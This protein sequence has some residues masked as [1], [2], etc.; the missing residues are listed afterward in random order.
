[1]MKLRFFIWLLFLCAFCV[2]AEQT[3]LPDI[4]WRLIGPFRGGRALAVAGVPGNPNQFYFGSVN[5]GVWKTND[6]GRTWEPIFD[7][8]S[9]ASIG[10]IAVAPSKPEVIYVGSGEAD[11]RS[12]IG[13]GNGMY[14]SIDG[15]KSWTHIGLTDS[16]QIGR[17]LINPQNPDEVFVAALGHAYGPNTERG[18]FH[19]TD[20]GKTWQKSLYRDA[21]TGVIDVAFGAN[22][23]MFAAMWQTRRT[24]WNV[25]PPYSGPGSGLYKSIDHGNTWKQISGHGFP[26]Q[27]VGRIGIGVSMSNPKIIFAVVDAKAG[28]LY[29]SDDDGENWTLV[30]SDQRIWQRGW[31]FGGVTV[32]PSTPDTVYVCNTTMYKSTDGGKNFV[33]FRGAP[34][35]DDYHELRIDPEDPGRMIVAADQGTVITL[36]GGKTWSSWYNQPTGQF[37]HGI[38]DDRFPYWVFGAQQDSGAAG[39]PSRTTNVDGIN[40]MQFHEVTAGGEN[41]YIAPDPLDPE[42]IY[43][44]TVEKL[45]TRTGQTLDVDPTFAYPDIYRRV[46]TLPLTFSPRDPHVLYFA[47]Q[48]LF[49]TNDGGKH[50][51]LI[52]PDMTRTEWPVPGNLNAEIAKNAS[53]LEP[54][55]GVIYSIA[56]S[57][58]VDHRIWIGTDDGLIWLTNDEGKNWEQVTPVALPPWSKVGIIEASHFDADTA[59][60]A[61]DRHR[62]DDYKPYI[63]RTHDS[64]KTWESIIAGIPDGSFVNVI[65]E[66]PLKKGMLYAGTELGIYFSKDDGEH[67]QPL[68]LNLPV[69]SIR[70]IDVHGDDLVV[71]THGRAFW[72][73]DNISPLRQD[74]DGTTNFLFQPAV[75]YRMHPE[76]FTG[77]PWP[78]DEP[79]AENP[80]DG[81]VIDYYLKRDSKMPVTLEILTGSG[82]LV[83]RFSSAD[84]VTKP[85][86]SKIVVTP[87]W[88]KQEAVLK[89]T[90]GF[91]RFVWDIRYPFRKELLDPYQQY[92][93]N[94]GIPALPGK[95]TVR[96]SIDGQSLTQPLEVKNDPRV[97]VSQQDLVAQFE[98]A[99]KLDD[100]RIRLAQKINEAKNLLKQSQAARA[101]A[102]TTLLKQIDQFQKGITEQT[103]IQVV[104]IMWGS[105]GS[106]PTK[107]TSFSYLS[108]AFSEMQKTVD[109]ADAAPSPDVLSGFEKLRAA[110]EEAIHQWEALKNRE[111]PE[112]NPALKNQHLPVLKSETTDQHR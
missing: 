43:G 86:L 50:W 19:T 92:A 111:L 2:D 27:G 102:S 100:E 29:R 95:Y 7:D 75:A 11:M 37:Y 33:P 42:I 48:Y 25:Y 110:T 105:P 97:Q 84:E 77:T 34:G 31:Y 78:K 99:K 6:A 71:A 5:G 81:A 101:K 28:G 55:R 94:K 17:V 63:F 108:R 32:D 51:D 72:I 64:G 18:L 14:K 106:F 12:D 16:H 30:S 112:I 15:G 21:D 46:W 98:F 74:F 41:G 68:Q 58:V 24:P 40:L 20:G 13:Y 26:D 85:D 53:T 83:R 56:P 45:D 60:V 35:G 80:P 9:I 70:D 22:E 109:G 36:N 73:L 52:S 49:R 57:P 96:I 3:R 65:R 82:D 4:H 87:D 59:Y 93:E 107:T 47:N 89:S 1:M 10:A 8:Q 66:D 91:H 62:L 67:F 79:M 103:E 104:P 76:G 23:T 61:I 90:A 54:R 69:T 44:G 88:V 39:V 38:T